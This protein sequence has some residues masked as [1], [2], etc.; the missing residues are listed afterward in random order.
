ML[1]FSIASRD[2]WHHAHFVVAFVSAASAA[3]VT[4]FEYFSFHFPLS[5]VNQRM[6]LIEHVG[7]LVLI[8][9]LVPSFELNYY[10]Y[11]Y[12]YSDAEHDVADYDVNYVA[13]LPMN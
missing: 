12:Y 5:V 8:S 1:H 4:D 9:M 3:V 10:Y 7:N 11:Y 6:F 13:P 2:F